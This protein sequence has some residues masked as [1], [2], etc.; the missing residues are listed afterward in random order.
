MA[1]ER[2]LL[3]W[4]DCWFDERQSGPYQITAEQLARYHQLLADPDPAELRALRQDTRGRQLPDGFVQWMATGIIASRN[5]VS[6]LVAQRSEHYEFAAA[7]HVGEPFFIRVRGDLVAAVDERSGIADYVTTVVTEDGRLI[8][9]Q[10]VSGLILRRP[11]SR[12]DSSP[13]PTG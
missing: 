7:L 4:E 2:R 13:P 1:D 12:D 9:S 6:A 11:R 3:Y 10:R 5:R 8:S